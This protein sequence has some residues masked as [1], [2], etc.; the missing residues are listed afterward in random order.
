MAEIRTRRYAAAL[1]VVTVL[2]GL[3]AYALK[4]FDVVGV[5]FFFGTALLVQ[6]LLIISFVFSLVMA[7]HTPLKIAFSIL[8]S[9]GQGIQGNPYI[10]SLRGRY[11]RLT[12]TPSGWS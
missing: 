5:P 8:A 3:N 6:L 1:A 7:L 9:A 4:T 11:P 10:V 2:T 12:R